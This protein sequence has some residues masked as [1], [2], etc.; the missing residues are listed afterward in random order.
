MKY[1]FIDLPYYILCFIYTKFEY[2]YAKLIRLPFDIRN[3]SLIKIGK[4]FVSGRYCRIEAFNIGTNRIIIGNN[5]QINDFVH[6]VAN[7]LVQIGD[8]VLIA[9]KVFISDCNHGSYGKN[10][11]HS[12][13][14]IPPKDRILS[15][16]SV[17]I[18]SNVWIGE[19]VTILEG[20]TIGE[21]SI[22]GA[23][24]L[25]NKDI[26]PYT[27]AIGIPATPIKFY[28]FNIQQWKKI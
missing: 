7:N 17:I 1:R 23:M 27:I 18:K 25:V 9:S 22:I 19:G 6:I 16:N 15:N 24:S 4:N 28:D 2:K 3:K 10:N 14:L 26:P 5:V 8:N 11:I 21:G 13:P 20:V 12:N